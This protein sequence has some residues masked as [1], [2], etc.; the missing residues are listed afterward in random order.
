[1]QCN[2]SKLSAVLYD[3]ESNYLPTY[4]KQNKKQQKWSGGWYEQPTSS[5]NNKGPATNNTISQKNTKPYQV[6]T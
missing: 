4:L 1:M 2:A 6:G 3:L 5:E